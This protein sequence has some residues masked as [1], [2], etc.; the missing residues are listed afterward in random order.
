MK[1]FYYKKKQQQQTEKIPRTYAI[2]ACSSNQ[3]IE[4]QL[5]LLVTLFCFKEVSLTFLIVV[6]NEKQKEIINN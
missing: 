6:Q 3:I 2:E 5:Q 1:Y 4:N